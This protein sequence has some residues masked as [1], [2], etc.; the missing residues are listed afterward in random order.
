MDT[1]VERQLLI[2][3][4]KTKLIP[5]QKLVKQTCPTQQ[6]IHVFFGL[7]CQLNYKHETLDKSASLVIDR[8]GFDRFS[9]SGTR[10][11]ESHFKIPQTATIQGKSNE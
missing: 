10:A 1:R 4:Q 7:N 5:A 8:F 9:E 3:P 2:S 11:H 6:K